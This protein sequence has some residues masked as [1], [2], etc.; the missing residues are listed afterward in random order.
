MKIGEEMEYEL[1]FA[2]ISIYGFEGVK[3]VFYVYNFSIWST[4]KY[5][6]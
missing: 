5:V 2:H 3:L 6:M 4:S 1:P